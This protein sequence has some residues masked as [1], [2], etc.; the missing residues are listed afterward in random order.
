VSPLRHTIRLLLKSPGFTVTAVLILGFGIGANTAIFSLINGVLLKPLSYSHSERLVKLSMPY[1]NAQGAGVDY[2]DYL[3]IAGGQKSFDSMALFCQAFLDLT[4]GGETQ[5]LSAEF[6]APSLFTLTGRTPVLGRTF[7]QQEDIPHGPLLAVISERFWK[8]HFNAD[9]SVIG[10]KLTVSEQTFEIIGVV[11]AQMDLW[12]PP[13]TDLYLPVNSIA[14]FSFPIYQRTYHIFGCVGRLKEGVSVAQAQAE[15]EVI[16]NGLVS[17]FPDTKKGYGLRIIPLLDDVVGDYS[18][19]VWLLG[20]AVVVLLLIAATNVANLLFVRGLER[21]RE[22]AIRSAIGAT[23]SRLV[24]QMLLETGL[25][26]LL[27]G[28]AGLVLALGSIEIIRK[29]SPA[30]VYR[31]QEVRIDITALLFVVGIIVLV[32][33]ISGVVPALS[34]SKPRLGPVLNQ[35]G[36]RG[37]TGGLEKHRAQTILV[38]AQVALA[39]ILLIGAGLLVRSFEAA[40]TAPLGF[41][42]HQILTAQLFLTSSTYEADSVKTVAFYDSVLAKVRHLPG[43]SEVAMNDNPPLYYRWGSEWQFTV[44]GQTDPGVGHRPVFSWQM[45]SPNYFRTLEI[46][47]LKG[48]DFNAGDKVDREQVVIID[49]AMAQTCFNGLNP[50]GRVI[51]FNASEGTRH[52]TIVG[53]VPHVRYRN[54]G[55]AENR[56]QAY[57]PYSQWD[58]DAEVLLL[59]CQGDP[60]DQ[61][62]AVRTAVRSVDPDVPVPDIRTFDDMIA[63]KLI[64]RK[65]ASTLVSL[66]SGAALC[67]SAIGLYGVLAY[68][69]SQRRREIGVRIALGAESSK[70]LKLVAQ[71]GFK[72]I[73]IGLMIGVFVALVCARFIEGMLYGVTAADPISLLVAAMVLCLAGC[74]A[75][76]LPALRAIRIN[77][78]TALRE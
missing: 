13:A 30:E 77:P 20:V 63:E 35:G 15:L 33:F 72:L 69:V 12:G 8:S 24:A 11:P 57:F 5:R 25:L 68:S 26:S 52:C 1:Q 44:E 31:F 9:P 18:G 34:L 42:P 21:R 65:L 46:P 59:R 3:D 45:I 62:G 76:L 14:L 67:L 29:L 58:F 61:I 60:N 74:V 16:N 51:N 66:F 38:A 56:F 41:N 64:T 7:N 54:P 40:Q 22:L 27:G 39:C 4:G 37:G 47:I 53:V 2:P 50:V 73:G 23:R 10:K 49:E 32:A 48:R 43:V 36:G 71:Q 28:I 6:A 55:T 70:I 19:T 17:R 78:V 75:C